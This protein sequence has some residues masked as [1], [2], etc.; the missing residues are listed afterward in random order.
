VP[1]LRFRVERLLDLIG[2][3]NLES[4]E[5]V[6]FRL[7]GELEWGEEG[8]A[9]IELNPDRPDM[10]IGEGFARAARGLLGFETGYRRPE[11]VDSGVK[12]SA[13]PVPQR[14][15]I[16]AAVVYNVNVDEVFLEELIQ[17]QEK[18]HDTIGRRRRKVAIG[19]H[20]LSK[21]PGR[22]VEYRLVD[23]GEYR[24]KPLHGAGEM[25]VARVLEET[26]QGRLYGGIAL[27]E[28]RH[29]ALISGGEIIAIPPVINSDI[30]RVEP[31]TRD[32]FIDVTGTDERAVQAT[33][34]VIV[35]GL[36]ERPGARVGSVEVHGGLGVSRTPRLESKSLELSASWASR[37]LGVKVGAGELVRL[38]ERARH[39]ARAESEDRVVAE[40]PPYRVDVLGPIDL[41]EDVA[42]MIGY[43]ALEPTP[44]SLRTRGG[45][46]RLTQTARAFKRL[47]VGLGFT[48]SM[49]MV[50]TSPRLVEVVG[51]GDRVVRVSNPV[52][53]E[54][55][56]L[57]PSLIVS[58]LQFLAENQHVEKPVK[59][60]EVGEVVWRDGVEVSE[61]YRAALAFMG[62]SASFE[63]VQAPLY[64]ILRILGVAFEPR[65]ERLPWAI[66]GRSA[67]LV[68]PG[69]ETL[70]WLGEVH[71]RVL[72]ALGIEYPVAAAEL[73]LSA[74]A[75]GLG[76]FTIRGLATR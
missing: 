27:R 11:L 28:G 48:E 74:I 10:Y 42:M 30:T 3:N 36:A 59:V 51:L 15:Y 7:K 62:E 37:I 64:S 71:P 18:L 38:L 61:D 73:S 75:G 45:L 32:L 31:G 16:A 53:V 24:M 44:P 56:V 46:D 76:R 23:V 50:L 58:L 54:Y 4:L 17:F 43:E 68:E 69:G 5:D 72:E 29:P 21:L 14:P 66:E 22:E 19:F 33:L 63:D 47:A 34:E 1:V 57:R 25:T 55:S 8:Y 13:G 39:N 52:Q 40:V 9:Y 35:G 70:A 26:E 20:D 67:A 2:L 41:V 60:F 49:Q 6:V 65:E 12:L